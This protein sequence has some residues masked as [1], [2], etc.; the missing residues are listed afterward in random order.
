MK[1]EWSSDQVDLH[2]T[3]ETFDQPI[4]DLLNAG[5]TEDLYGSVAGFL[6][7]FTKKFMLEYE[8]DELIK[9]YLEQLNQ[10]RQTNQTTRV[11]WAT[12]DKAMVVDRS[13][14]LRDLW[15][16]HCIRIKMSRV[17]FCFIF[18][19]SISIFSRLNLI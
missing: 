8:K 19:F 5:A 7:A 13:T 17:V 1:Y 14:E 12:E 4:R 11:W 6:K 16:A 3:V 9:P 2:L 18:C 15:K 10:N